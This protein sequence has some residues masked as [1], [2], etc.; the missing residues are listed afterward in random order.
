MAAPAPE[1]GGPVPD[2]RDGGRP[3]APLLSAPHLPL[4]QYTN[5][6]FDLHPTSFKH[7]LFAARLPGG[8]IRWQLCPSEELFRH[9][10]D[11]PKRI[12]GQLCKA[13]GKVVEA[14]AASGVALAPDSA[15]VDVGAA[16]GGW[17]AQLAAACGHVVAIDPGELHLLVNALPNPPAPQMRRRDRRLGWAGG[18][19]TWWCAT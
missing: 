17:T 5:P 1:N 9:A 10:C 14:L 12:P 7:V 11:A 16:P 15:A 18:R 13:A 19:W 4:L 2:E 3:P 8:D 6:Q